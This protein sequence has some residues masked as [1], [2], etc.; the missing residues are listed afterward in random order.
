MHRVGRP[1]NTSGGAI[2]ANWKLVYS[3]GAG[4][5][6]RCPS[7]F[8]FGGHKTKPTTKK[9]QHKNRPNENCSSTSGVS[10]AECV[11]S[12]SFFLLFFCLLLLLLLVIIIIVFFFAVLLWLTNITA[13]WKGTAQ[14]YINQNISC[15]SC[16]EFSISIYAPRSRLTLWSVLLLLLLSVFF[17]SSYLFFFLF[18]FSI[19]SYLC[20]LRHLHSIFS[21]VFRGYLLHVYLISRRRI[22]IIHFLG[23]N[24]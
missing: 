20:A 14:L 2:N 18:L 19:H 17:S 10:G 7:F 12:F 5:D 23:G 4:H 1:A 8:F 21:P 24:T 6:N 9:P 11:F 3:C 15:E 22:I 16:D 13:R